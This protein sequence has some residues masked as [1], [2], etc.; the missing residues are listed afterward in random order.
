MY[1][2]CEQPVQEDDIR[3]NREE[4][5]KA[6]RTEIEMRRGKQVATTHTLTEF[7]NDQSV[8]KLTSHL[9]WKAAI[10]NDNEFFNTTKFSKCDIQ[11]IFKCYGLKY[12]NSY[13]K[14]NLAAELAAAVLSSDSMPMPDA[15]DQTGDLPGAG[16]DTSTVGGKG[17]GKGKTSGA[18]KKR[19]ACLENICVMC[20]VEYGECTVEETWIECD[21]CQRW[22][23]WHCGGLEKQQ[24]DN[25]GDDDQFMCPKCK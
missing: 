23:H 11:L 14:A 21:K 24:A 1:A 8:A 19:K 17:K 20:G 9:L 6:H 22:V 25:M 3:R 15:A 13:R 7:K 16:E 10:L 12:H 18:G 4:E 5:K 2:G